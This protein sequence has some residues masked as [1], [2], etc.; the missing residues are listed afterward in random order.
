M[1]MWGDV[2]EEN[3]PNCVASQAPGHASVSAGRGR[4]L[5]TRMRRG[6]TEAEACEGGTG[7]AGNADRPGPCTEPLRTQRAYGK[8]LNWTS[9]HHHLSLVLLSVI[10]ASFFQKEGT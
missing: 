9:A 2:A 10:M 4:W 6:G 3:I 1:C 7:S 8:F 5:P